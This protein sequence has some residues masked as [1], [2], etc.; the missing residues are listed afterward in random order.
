MIAL[1]TEKIVIDDKEEYVDM[2]SIVGEE[3]EIEEIPTIDKVGLV[4]S[5]ALATQASHEEL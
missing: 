5:C 1:P 4:A 3:D 2:P